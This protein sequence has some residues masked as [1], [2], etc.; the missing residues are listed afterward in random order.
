[1]NTAL[2]NV[3]LWAFSYFLELLGLLN[4]LAILGFSAFFLFFLPHAIFT[5]LFRLL[6]LLFTLLH[7]LLDSLQSLWIDVWD[8]SSAAPW[9]SIKYHRL[10][11]VEDWYFHWWNYTLFLRKKC[12]RSAWLHHIWGP[13][14]FNWNTLFFWNRSCRELRE[15]IQ[16]W[17]RLPKDFFNLLLGFLSR[18][19]A[20]HELR[21]CGL[22]SWRDRYTYFDYFGEHLA[23]IFKFIR[24]QFVA[25]NDYFA[26]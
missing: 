19:T 9:S 13:S 23:E 12:N 8:S 24:V 22:V 11:R 2:N 20:I 14:R 16:H 26:L 18:G 1:M 17:C 25:I 6:R 3:Y 15:S 5:C 21:G 7:I 10:L 4:K